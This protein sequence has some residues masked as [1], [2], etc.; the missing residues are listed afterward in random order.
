MHANQKKKRIFITNQSV[1]SSN[2]IKTQEKSNVATVSPGL[3]QE[4]AQDPHHQHKKKKIH[5]S[6]KTEF[7][8]I[9]YNKK[10]HELIS[11]TQELSFNL[12]F[13]WHETPSK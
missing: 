8:E 12:K 9:F 7:G 13:F 4:E 11:L 1:R 5:K 10:Q 3:G 2:P 6:I